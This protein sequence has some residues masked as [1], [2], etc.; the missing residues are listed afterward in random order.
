MQIDRRFL[1]VAMPQQ[2][3]DGAQVG[4]GFEQM[5]G[6]AVAQ[7]VGM[8]VL[9]FKAGAFGGLLTGVPENLGGDRMTRRMPSVAGKQPV[10]GLA[11]Q[12]A[13]VD[14]KGI[15]QLRAEHDIAVLAPLASPD[16]NDHPLAVDI[17]DLQVR[18]FCAT[19]AR[20]IE[21]HQQD[22]MKG[23]LCRVDQPRDFFL[24]EHLR[25]VQNLLRIRRLGNAPAALQHLD[26]EEAQ[27]GQAL[28]YGVREPASSA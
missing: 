15:E 8:D 11:L 16:M 6:K 1:Q 9:V 10:G 19:C 18:H 7:S 26:I 20:G 23:K 13:P 28:G 5:R 14:A 21:R 3:L 4:A 24:A 12:P 2:H 25:Q 27:S 22:A 17:A